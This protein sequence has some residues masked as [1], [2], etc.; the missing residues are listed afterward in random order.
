MTKWRENAPLTAKRNSL[1][2]PG[3]TN[4]ADT[5]GPMSNNTIISVGEDFAVDPRGASLSHG[6]NI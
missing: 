3:D 6:I 2:L 5:A 1:P 4:A